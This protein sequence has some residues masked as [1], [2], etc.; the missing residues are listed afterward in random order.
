MSLDASCIV[1]LFNVVN[2]KL[3]VKILNTDEKY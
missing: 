1:I 3:K 2:P